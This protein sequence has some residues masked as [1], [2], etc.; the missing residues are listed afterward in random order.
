MK[1]GGLWDIRFNSSKANYNSNSTVYV[2]RFNLTALVAIS[3][4]DELAKGIFYTN[5]TGSELNQQFNVEI[6]T[7]NNATWNYNTTDKKTEYWIKNTGTNPEDFCIKTTSDL[8]CSV[9]ACAGQTIS[10][11]NVAW[12]NATTTDASNPSYDTNKR[13][14]LNYV[15]V[16]YGISPGSKIYLRFWLFVPI[17]KPSGIYNTTYSVKAVEAGGTC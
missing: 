17:G 11:D 1:T 5:R 15:K 10:I 7:W 3:I 9:G 16:G 8:T 2:D 13:L 12:N 6:N 4:S 14:S